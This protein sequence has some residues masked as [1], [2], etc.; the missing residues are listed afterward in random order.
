MKF[1]GYFWLGLIL[2][3]VALLVSTLFW[4]YAD[5]WWE[6]RSLQ[7]MQTR[8]ADFSSYV[9]LLG[10]PQ[11][12][13]TDYHSLEVRDLSGYEFPVES[14]ERPRLFYFWAKEG[15]PYYGVLIEVEPGEQ[16]PEVVHTEVPEVFR[17]MFGF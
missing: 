15:I 1:L 5:G 10:E 12:A 13:F 9:K 2:S 8:R 16:T 14:P 11:F 17:W 6:R 4:A 7:A 3:Y